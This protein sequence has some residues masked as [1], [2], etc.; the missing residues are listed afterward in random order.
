MK[1]I[2]ELVLG[3]KIFKNLEREE[4]K[5]QDNKISQWKFFVVLV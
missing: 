5:S 1:Y 2:P 4:V 3:L